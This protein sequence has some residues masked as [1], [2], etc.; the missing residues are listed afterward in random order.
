MRNAMQAL[1][2]YRGIGLWAKSRDGYSLGTLESTFRSIYTMAY[3]T[4][5]RHS[6]TTSQ[7]VDGDITPMLH[8]VNR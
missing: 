1:I 3:G 4:A 2:S 5:F 6:T 7:F 8:I